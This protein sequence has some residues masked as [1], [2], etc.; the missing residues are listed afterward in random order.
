[1]KYNSEQKKKTLA[2]LEAESREEIKTVRAKQQLLS[3]Q[4]ESERLDAGF[5]F[6]VVFAT[7]T[8]RDEWLKKQKVNLV[9]DEY[10]LASK[11]EIT[12]QRSKI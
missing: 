7:R 10:I 6:S 2:A 8:E 1:M 12:I 11:Y 4:A 3:R 9:D 5:F